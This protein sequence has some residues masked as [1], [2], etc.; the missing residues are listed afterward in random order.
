VDPCAGTLLWAL[1]FG[2]PVGEPVVSD[3]DGDGRNDVLV[4]VADGFL[5]QVGDEVLPAPEWVWDTDPP[6]GFPAEDRDTIETVDTLYASWAAVPGAASYEY[7]V[8]T[9]G[10]TFV[11][12]PPFVPVGTATSAAPT[13]LP[14]RL[15]GMYQFVVRAIGPRGGSRETFSDGIQLVD[16]SP[17]T[18]EL[19]AAPNPFSP[20]G[21]G[22]EDTVTILA[23]VAD[24]VGLASW[25]IA[26]YHPGGMAVARNFP[27]RPLLGTSTSDIVVWDGTDDSG[28][29][30]T[31][32]VYPALATVHDRTGHSATAWIDLEIRLL[33]AA[34]AD[35]DAD[36]G[37]D[38]EADAEPEVDAGVDAEGDT[39]PEADAEADAGAD[40]DADGGFDAGADTPAADGGGEPGAGGWGGRAGGHATAGGLGG[41]L[42]GGRLAG[43]P[44]PAREPPR[45]AVPSRP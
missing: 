31:Q 26:V 35:A 12:T 24:R 2:F 44:R 11:T 29:L 6:G 37:A 3:T 7:G 18:V 22:V 39:E 43:R 1:R 10:G 15:G 17:P 27:S 33:G 19:R 25:E 45:A 36:G 16:E 20:D 21:D 42:R 4:S 5:Y 13:G 30:L 8:V 40:A 32:S 23:D 34:D 38:G 41:L 14:L 28:R 9:P